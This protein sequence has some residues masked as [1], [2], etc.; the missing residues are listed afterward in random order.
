MSPGTSSSPDCTPTLSVFIEEMLQPSDHLC[1]SLMGWFR[2]VLV[3]LVL[4]AP[5]LNAVLQ[6]AAPGGRAE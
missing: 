4:G 3:L 6:V 5:E 2:Q 1:G